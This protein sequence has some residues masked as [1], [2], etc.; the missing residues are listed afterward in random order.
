MV[1]IVGFWMLAAGWLLMAAHFGTNCMP[2]SDNRTPSVGRA[3]IVV[4]VPLIAAAA[5]MIGLHLY[6]IGNQGRW[7]GYPLD[8]LLEWYE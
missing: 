1:E 5:M 4:G 6:Y 3:W 8:V 2:E 7:P